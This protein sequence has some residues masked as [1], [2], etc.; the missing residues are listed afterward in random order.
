MDYYHYAYQCPY[1]TGVENKEIHCEG[2]CRLRFEMA[3]YC[4]AYLLEYCANE[5]G[6]KNCTIAMNKNNFY[7]NDYDDWKKIEGIK[8]NNRVPPKQ[9]KSTAKCF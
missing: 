5:N 7:K 2:G 1:E 6:W 4:K 3:K 8:A 9:K